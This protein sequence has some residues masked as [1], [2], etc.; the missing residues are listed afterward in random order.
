MLFIFPMNHLSFPHTTNSIAIFFH[1]VGQIFTNPWIMALFIIS[2][3]ASAA[4]S[5]NTP[6]WLALITDVNLPEHRG[7]V[8][9]IANFSNSLGRTVGNLGIGALLTMVSLMAHHPND[10]VFTLIILQ[11]SLIPSALCY[12]IMAK[13]N[14]TDISYV[15][16]TLDKRGKIV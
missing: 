3:L 6:N 4:Q 2:F 1:L 16:E 10:Y 9:S 14:V 8:F 15:K 12:V 13:H 5:A 11:L 7:A